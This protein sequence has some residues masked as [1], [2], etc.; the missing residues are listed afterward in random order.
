[1]RPLAPAGAVCRHPR[2]RQTASERGQEERRF[3]YLRSTEQIR[4][5]DGVAWI[6]RRRQR[7]RSELG[8]SA[9][10]RRALGREPV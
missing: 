5:L 2:L 10:F 1:M 6:K 7:W 4:T 9:C 8:R 3:F